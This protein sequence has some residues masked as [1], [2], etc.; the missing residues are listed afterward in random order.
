MRANDIFIFEDLQEKV[1]RETFLNEMVFEGIAETK[2]DAMVL[3]ESRVDKVIKDYSRR[4]TA[5]EP[6]ETMVF[7][8]RSNPKHHAILA[9]GS[10][11]F[12]RFDVIN[13]KVVSEERFNSFKDLLQEKEMLTLG[14]F[15]AVDSRSYLQK[16]WK[17]LLMWLLGGTATVLIGG[18]LI[19]A[20]IAT[21]GSAVAFLGKVMVGSAAVMVGLR[22]GGW[23]SNAL[24][25]GDASNQRYNDS[26]R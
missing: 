15:V 18:P 11:M 13:G 8:D 25:G 24:S 16:N 23:I 2:E 12:Y 5:G 19:L 14:T 26:G 4:Y 22:G 9:S 3:L 1:E 10:N 6:P 17:K 21:F 7:Q 20:W